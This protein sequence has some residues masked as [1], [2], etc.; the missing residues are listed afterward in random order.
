VSALRPFFEQH[1]P[2]H[3]HDPAFTSLRGLSDVVAIAVRCGDRTETHHLWF[4]RGRLAQG[5]PPS[6]TTPR[7]TFAV[8]HATFQQIVAAEIAPH[9]AFFTGRL[10]IHGDVLFGL[11]VGTLLAS[12][13]RRHPWRS[14]EATRG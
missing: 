4:E 14:P 6:H 13:F 9:T 1:V 5:T 12:F 7:T 8:S 10:T 3:A 2:A 11:Q